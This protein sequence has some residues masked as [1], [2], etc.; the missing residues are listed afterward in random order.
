MPDGEPV[1]LHFT[2]HEITGGYV[3]PRCETGLPASSYA[4][5]ALAVADAT[6]RGQYR[7]DR[8]YVLNSRG[9]EVRNFISGYSFAL[10]PVNVYEVEPD[11]PLEAD[12]DPTLRDH[13]F[14]SRCC[15]RARVLR[16]VWPEPG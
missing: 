8:V 4:G 14:A 6:A 11:P 10:E 5:S 15:P 12:P 13:Y 16:Q 2:R 9:L 3:L 1:W 7:D